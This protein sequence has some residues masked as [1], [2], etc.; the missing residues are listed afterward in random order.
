MERIFTPK[1]E[2]NI[3]LN[4]FLGYTLIYQIIAYI[5]AYMFSYSLENLSEDAIQY[6]AMALCIIPF[7]IYILIIA[8]KVLKDAWS[9]AC[10]KS[11]FVSTCVKRF[12]LTLLINVAIGAMLSQ[13][14]SGGAENQNQILEMIEVNPLFMGF[15]IVIFAPI[16]EEVV[17]REVLYKRLNVKYGGNIALLVSSVIFGFMHIIPNL[18]VGKFEGMIYI[19]QYIALG[20]ILGYIFKKDENISSGIV[21]HMLNNLFG[22][23]A[24]LILYF[25][26]LNGVV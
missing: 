9:Y 26:K 8:R 11:K 6:L 17:F 2:L 10:S 16:V 15:N 12:G 23:S 25:M 4:Y 21:V 7:F 20:Y 19:I 22:Y 18:L 1:Q 14:V 13:I 24:I 3:I 5:I